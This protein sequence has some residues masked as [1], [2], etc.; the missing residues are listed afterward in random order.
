MSFLSD[1]VGS[2]YSHDRVYRSSSIFSVAFSRR[3]FQL[4]S[5]IDFFGVV[6]RKFCRR[7]P[8][9][10]M[11]LQVLQLSSIQEK[12]CQ[13]DMANDLSKFLRVTYDSI[14]VYRLLLD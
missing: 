5:G 1:S 3:A 14:L 2:I 9:G 10:I 8:R 6:P 7:K 11:G 4:G 12:L 13:R